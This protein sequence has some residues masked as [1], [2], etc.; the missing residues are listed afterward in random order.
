MTETEGMKS[1]SKSF[2]QFEFKVEDDPAEMPV[3]KI[4]TEFGCPQ[5]FNGKTLSIIMVL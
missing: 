5:T 1:P 3:K 4:A 2:D